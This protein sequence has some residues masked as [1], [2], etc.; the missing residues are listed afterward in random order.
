MFFV[1]GDYIFVV[2]SAWH[3]SDAFSTNEFFEKISKILYVLEF[4]KNEIFA[5]NRKFI[6]F[7][8]NK[9]DHK[10]AFEE[11]KAKYEGQRYLISRVP[12]VGTS[13]RVL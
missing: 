11:L 2:I 1:A 3:F 6:I 9:T 13:L 12:T 10:I 7:G 4:L 5:E 8:M